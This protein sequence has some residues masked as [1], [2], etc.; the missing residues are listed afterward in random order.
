[1][2]RHKALGYLAPW[3]ELERFRG[4]DDDD[5]DDDS[6]AYH[7]GNRRLGTLLVPSGNINFNLPFPLKSWEGGI[8]LIYT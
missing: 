1:M 2:S 4:G 3:G 5:D 7:Q 8:I 6:L